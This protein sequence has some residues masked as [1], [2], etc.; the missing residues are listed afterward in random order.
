MPFYK[1]TLPFSYETEPNSVLLGNGIQ[2]KSVWGYYVREYT[3]T[4]GAKILIENIDQSTHYEFDD[5]AI[6]YRRVH[7]WLYDTYS[8]TTATESL[9]RGY[10]FYHDGNVTR[11]Q[12]PYLQPELATILGFTPD[13]NTILPYIET[14]STETLQHILETASQKF[15]DHSAM[16]AWVTVPL[17]APEQAPEDVYQTLRKTR[18]DWGI[19]PTRGRGKMLQYVMQQAGVTLDENGWHLTEIEINRRK[20]LLAQSSG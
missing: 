17:A 15:T 20:Q 14:V 3:D 2:R 16:N 11:A 4:R 6:N 9:A 13:P 19:R 7:E 10:R 1:H 8:T 18:M 5:F 12:K